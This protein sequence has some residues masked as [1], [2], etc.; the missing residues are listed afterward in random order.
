MSRPRNVCP[1]AGC[2][3]GRWAGEG[4]NGCRPAQTHLPLRRAGRASPGGTDPAEA[5]VTRA[6]CALTFLRLQHAPESCVVSPVT[7]PP[8]LSGKTQNQGSALASS[9]PNLSALCCPRAWGS[10]TFGQLR[11]GGAESCTHSFLPSAKT[12]APGGCGVPGR[13]LGA[14]QRG[15]RDTDRRALCEA[16]PLNHPRPVGHGTAWHGALLGGTEAAL[17]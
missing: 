8:S 6:L 13:Q 4:G 16:V 7:C 14:G 15:V 5:A 11:G 3:H 9:A 1:T 12:S 2:G 17:K 10:G